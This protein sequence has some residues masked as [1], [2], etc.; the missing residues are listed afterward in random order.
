MIVVRHPRLSTPSGFV[1][2]LTDKLVS[3]Q[4]AKTTAEVFGWKNV[5]RYN[6][7]PGRLRKLIAA[8]SL[9]RGYSRRIVPTLAR[10]SFL[11]TM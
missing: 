5:R 6:V 4:F 8:C 7:T 2:L 3:E 1:L 11:L 10:L 9:L